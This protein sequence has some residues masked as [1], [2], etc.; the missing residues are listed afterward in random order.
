MKWNEHFEKLYGAKS[1]NQ[2]VPILKKRINVALS[3]IEQNREEQK[4]QNVILITYPDQ[5]WEEGEKKLVTF[6]KFAQAYLK[7]VFDVIHFLPFYPFSSDDGFSVIDYRKIEDSLGDWNNLENIG[8]DYTLMYD[9]VCNH[10]SKHNEWFQKCLQGD[11]RYENFFIE[12]DPTEDLSL[13]TRPRTSSLLTQFET[14][15]GKKYYWTTFSQDQIDLNYKNPEVLYEAVDIFLNYL[16]K[17]G[18][19]IRLDAV[20]FLWKEIGTSCMNHKKTHE[21]VKLL[22]AIMHEVCPSGKIITETN[23]SYQENISYFGNETDESHMVYQFPL[24]FL[25]LYSFFRQNAKILSKWASELK[26]PSNETSFFNFLASHDGIGINPVRG[27][28]PEEEIEKLIIHLQEESGARVSYKENQDGKKNAYEINVSYF[29]AIKENLDFE[30][31]LIRFLN[32]HAVLLGMKGNPAIY[33]HSYLG[34]ENNEDGVRKTKMNRTINREKFEW[35]K[36]DKILK[37]ENSSRAR[38]RKE[39]EQLIRIRKGCD[40]F[41]AT[42]QQEIIK[43][44]EELF[45]Y[46]RRG[47]TQTVLCLHNFSSYSVKIPVKISGVDLFT[48][49][50]ILKS[51]TIL[52]YGFRWISI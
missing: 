21:L 37:E 2:W 52:P 15:K 26:L 27:I 14:T 19:W 25:V 42:A 39:M 1:A 51:L 49:E 41:A 9:F 35:S 28:V 47:K 32:A 24:P 29:S 45:S 34:S 6:Q 11:K 33:I 31:G 4:Q 23:V 43:G 8:E 38:I 16:E 36:I 40:A 13:V 22:R 12:T 48:G 7:G 50:T 30:I 10:V 44:S 5:F 18:R 17:G 20:G 46:I 3:L